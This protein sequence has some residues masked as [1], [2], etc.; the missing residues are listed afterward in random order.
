MPP[1]TEEAVRTVFAYRAARADGT[2]ERGT[3]TA[4]TRDAAAA[5]LVAG[6]SLPVELR[7]ARPAN[8]TSARS[9]NATT[10]GR[11]DGLP[12]D[13]RPALPP[14]DLALG[15]RAL[16]TLL[17]AELPMGRTLAAFADLA[18]A[19]WRPALPAIEG[20][21]R[22]G[23]GLSAALESAPVR[24][25]P[26]V[27]GL[28]RAGEAG[29][30]LAGAVRQA[31][32]LTERTAR[33][34]AALR[35][36]LAYPALLAAAATASVAL[37]VGVVLPRFAALLEGIGQELPWSTRVVLAA[38]A[39]ARGGAVPALGLAGATAVAWHAWT[40]TPAGRVAWHAALLRAPGLGTVR[41]AAAT[42]RA[43]AALAALLERG[44]PVAAALPHAA[45]AAGDAAV[46]A[47]LTDARAG[48]VA[49]ESVA[50]ALARTRAVTPTMVRLTRAG[51]ASGKLAAMCAHA[52]RLEAERAETLV[53]QTVR[54]V[55]PTLILGFGAVVALVAAALLQAVYSVRPGPGA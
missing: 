10:H 23:R 49:G 21:V 55:E 14:A 34:R 12:A 25:P 35:S 2:L 50:A 37:L 38:A 24:V 22:E 54:L 44:V 1:Q 41:S 15:L 20:A 33:T 30:G 46:E 9:P 36:A 48:I 40:R 4:A 26:V 16:A 7:A 11:A 31:A 52:A 28:L 47:R 43:A 3:V 19:S 18:P 13:R 51:E 8:G 17:D 5:V 45:R 32:D 6:G 42:A 53:A 27:V 29:S 39:V